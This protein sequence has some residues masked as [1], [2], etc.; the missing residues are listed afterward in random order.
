MVTP[1]DRSESVRNRCV[2][3]VF[4][5][6]CMLSRFGFYVGVGAFVIGLNEIS[7]FF[8]LH[9]LLS[10]NSQNKGFV[11]QRF[12]QKCLNKVDILFLKEF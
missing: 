2:I 5:G 3:D 11:M 7:S 10:K 6:I 12:L 4:G 9:V 1:T 8:S